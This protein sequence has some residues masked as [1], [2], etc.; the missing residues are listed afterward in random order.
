MKKWIALVLI[1]GAAS[2]G[3]WWFFHRAP[4]PQ[5]PGCKPFTAT[6]K[7]EPLANPANIKSPANRV[8]PGID[9]VRCDGQGK[10]RFD[11]GENGPWIKIVDCVSRATWHVDPPR[12][13]RAHAELINP[14]HPIPFTVP[15]LVSEPSLQFVSSYQGKE[16][17]NGYECRHYKGGSLTGLGTTEAWYAPELNCCVTLEVHSDYNGHYRQTLVNYEGTR[18]DAKLFDLGPYREVPC[19][20]FYGFP[21]RPAGQ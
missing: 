19:R 20:V 16:K 15:A 5:P 3:G 2:V 21:V 8:E 13:I 9:F 11:R 7:L 6:Y 10:I 17:V 18:P 14:H 1:V 4:E 12:G